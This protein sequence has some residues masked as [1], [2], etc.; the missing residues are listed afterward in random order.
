MPIGV[1]D[2][3]NIEYNKCKLTNGDVIVMISDGFLSLGPAVFE[4]YLCGLKIE[5]EDSAVDITGKIMYAA[6]TLGLIYKDD[7]SVVAVK[8]S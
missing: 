8:I 5:K 6:E 4:E 3:V 1:L 7:I 2:E